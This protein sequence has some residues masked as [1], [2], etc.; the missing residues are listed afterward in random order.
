MRRL[1][2]GGVS[3]G[4]CFERLGLANA[5]HNHDGGYTKKAQHVVPRMAGG[6]AVRKTG[7]SRASKVFAD[8]QEAVNYAKEAARK[9][10]GVMYIHRA[11][12]T[13]RGRSSFG[14]DAG[15]LKG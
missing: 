5:V 14:G 3:R 11:D 2:L 13:V 4:S 8:Q 6:W 1:R 10:G 9:E 12:G 15:S 7:A